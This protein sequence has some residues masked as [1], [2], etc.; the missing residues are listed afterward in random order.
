MQAD[1]ETFFTTDHYRGYPTALVRLARLSITDLHDLL[2][3]AWRRCAPKHLVAEYERR[4][5]GEATPKS[6]RSG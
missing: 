5:Q 4:K 6:G 2:E 1:P 3:Q